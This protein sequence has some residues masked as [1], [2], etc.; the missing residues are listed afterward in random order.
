MHQHFSL[1]IFGSTESWKKLQWIT[2]RQREGYT[3]ESSCVCYPEPDVESKG[4]RFH[5]EG[6]TADE[7]Q[8]QDGLTSP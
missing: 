1:E 4:E 2:S 5:Q 8:G 6:P 3:T 7:A